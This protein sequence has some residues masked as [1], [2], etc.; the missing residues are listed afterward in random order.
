MAQ[1]RKDTLEEVALEDVAARVAVAVQDIPQ[2]DEVAMFFPS[3]DV[4]TQDK[5][6]RVMNFLQQSQPTATQ[7][8]VRGYN[9]QPDGYN[10]KPI[11]VIGNISETSGRAVHW[12][13]RVPLVNEEH[14][15]LTIIFHRDR[16]NE[17]VETARI[18]IG[19]KGDWRPIDLDSFLRSP[20]DF[21]ASTM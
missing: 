3:L 8:I 13:A 9:D 18:S 16:L 17:D 14:T 6:L 20:R 19:K 2:G 12:F 11:L 15:P 5:F 21:F 7:K 4:N 1:I 10:N